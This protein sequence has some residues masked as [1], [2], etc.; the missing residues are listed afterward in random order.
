MFFSR[1]TLRQNAHKTQYFMETFKNSYTL[2]QAVWKLFSADP[3]QDRDFI[4]RLDQERHRPIIYAVSAREPVDRQ[5]FWKIESKVYKPRISSG[6]HFSFMIR[7]NPIRTKRDESGKQHRHD[8][9]MEA[10]TRLKTENTEE[11]DDIQKVS[12]IQKAGSLWLLSRAEKNGFKLIPDALRVDGYQQHRFSKK[13]GEKRISISTLDF[14][15]ILKISNPELFI[16]MLYKGIGPA[17]AFG[18][19]MLLIRRA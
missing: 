6:M 8:V 17:K 5:D 12:L 2:H 16:D 3:K 11:T 18:C 1:M 9:V 7:A 13:R 14:D 4:Y 15:G 19:G 10:K